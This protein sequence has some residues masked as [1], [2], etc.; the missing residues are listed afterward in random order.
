ML[1]MILYAMGVYFVERCWSCAISKH[2]RDHVILSWPMY[3]MDGFA[4]DKVRTLVVQN[5]RFYIST[6]GGELP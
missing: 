6:S 2:Y 4:V 1:G 3:C 5:C